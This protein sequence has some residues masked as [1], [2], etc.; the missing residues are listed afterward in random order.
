MGHKI[1][2]QTQ[3]HFFFFFFFFFYKTVHIVWYA[4]KSRFDKNIKLYSELSYSYRLLFG[5][6]ICII[7]Q[8]GDI[9]GQI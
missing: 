9:Q 1:G 2:Y 7:R 3:N 6:K 8:L 4:Q 5:S